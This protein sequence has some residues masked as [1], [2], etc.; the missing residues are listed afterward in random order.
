M[1]NVF[2]NSIRA[3]A[4]INGVRIRPTSIEVE[5][6]VGTSS[7]GTATVVG[8]M[9][10]PSFLKLDQKIEVYVR[11]SVPDGDEVENKIFTGT[12]KKATQ[13][14]E[15]K[16]TIEAYDV[17]QFMNNTKVKYSLNKPQSARVV[18][19]DVLSDAGI[20]NYT[21]ANNV[22]GG[23]T[24][25]KNEYGSGR[26]GT[27]VSKVVGDLATKL[28]S[29]VWVDKDNILNIKPYPNHKEF[30]ARYIKNISA[31]DE[32]INSNKTLVRS[33]GSDGSAAETYIYNR[34]K[35]TSTAKRE[36][37]SSS[38]ESDEEREFTID[39]NNIIT[40]D[41]ADRVAA[42]QQI[43]QEV[44]RDLGEI[45]IVSDPRPDLFDVV[46]LPDLR[47]GDRYQI[48]NETVTDEMMSQFLLN[49]Y[50]I[51]GISHKIDSTE[52]YTITLD[53]GPNPISQIESLLAEQYKDKQDETQ[54]DGIPDGQKRA[55][56]ENR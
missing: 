2:T 7:A 24:V 21:I 40:Q 52:G 53:L 16:I 1:T 33:K 11:V 56:E 30:T 35:N 42:S 44:A 3:R 17:R 23:T 22:P 31:G 47:T 45:T 51:S 13:D 41:E 6:T 29:R 12:V 55:L 15:G 54:L 49:G 19:D 25:G 4:E 20:E 39:D 37:D 5:Q 36:T 8:L 38:S 48:T 26:G 18:L 50:I 32:S 43:D 46:N 9:K 10:D 27:L 34:I 28:G 14:K